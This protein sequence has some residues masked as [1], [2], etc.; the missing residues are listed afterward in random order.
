MKF[1]SGFF[2]FITINSF[3]CFMVSELLEY[4]QMAS[5]LLV[6]AIISFAAILF[7]KLYRFF[8]MYNLKKNTPE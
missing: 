5:I 1:I 4:R 8:L 3:M 7:L 6:L 2:S